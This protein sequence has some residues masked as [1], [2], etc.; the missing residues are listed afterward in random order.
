MECERFIPVDVLDDLCSRFIINV[1]EE[2]RSDLIRICFQIESAHW[3]YIDFY[4]KNFPNRKPCGLREFAL[5][6]FRHIPFLQP[7]T[8]NLD[9]I[10]EDWKDYKFCVP[11]FGAILLDDDLSHVLLVQSYRSS[12]GFPKGK[13]NKDEPPYQCAIREVYEETGFDISHLIDTN[14]YLE[15]NVNEQIIRLY[16]IPGVKKCEK[17]VPKT[18]NEIKA[19]NWFPVYDIPLNKK[20]AFLKQM[21]GNNTIY[22]TF[23]MVSPFLRKIRQW[24]YENRMKPRR[25]HMKA[26]RQRNRSCSDI[27]SILYQ[28]RNLNFKES[29]EMLRS[30]KDVGENTPGKTVVSGG[31]LTEA[32]NLTR[33][34]SGDDVEGISET[35][36]NSLT[37][38]QDLFAKQ[39]AKPALPAIRET[40][41]PVEDLSSSSN[42]NVHK[43]QNIN[44][45]NRVML[46]KIKNDPN[47]KK[48][49]THNKLSCS[50]DMD[51]NATGPSSNGSPS[52]DSA[53]IKV[54]KSLGRRKRGKRNRKRSDEKLPI[55]DGDSDSKSGIMKDECESEQKEKKPLP[56]FEPIQEIP[57]WVGFK[58]D[59]NAIIKAMND[60]VIP[61]NNDEEQH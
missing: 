26:L 25:V 47:D 39:D 17:F 42:V 50:F 53:F 6:V 37:V 54:E 7:F 1:P 35:L 8:N 19:I 9:E 21:N 28:G 23:Y 3:F 43:L 27:D 48:A 16:I 4:S 11:T 49:R 40:L 56:D 30:F 13:V 14:D 38:S 34:K 18:R 46:K 57:G 12:W 33:K 31:D 45:D 15:A 10:I 59:I 60:A 52:S 51:Q 32:E 24:I 41:N 5:Q 36:K 61:K 20:D 44:P 22:N 55:A 2:E 58:F 29:V